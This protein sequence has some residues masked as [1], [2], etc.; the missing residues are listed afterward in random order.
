ML[1]GLLVPLLG[2]AQTPEIPS[3]LNS[4]DNA[5]QEYDWLKPAEDQQRQAASGTSFNVTSGQ[6]VQDPFKVLSSGTL[7]Q[8]K[9]DAVYTQR[10]ENA[11]SLSYETTSV[12]LN[13]ASNPT[14]PLEGG[15]P[16]DLSRGQKLGLQFQ[17]AEVLTLGC[18]LH[19]ATTDA[20][21]PGD[22]LI[23]SGFGLS[24]QGKLPFNAQLSLDLNSDRTST[25]T[26]SATET[27]DT[28]CNAEL[29]Q[30]LGKLPLTAVLK[31]H[32]EETFSQGTPA[33][34]LPSFEQS[35][36][37]KPL[38]TTTLQTGLRQQ[39]F[40]V[41]PGDQNTFNEALFADWSQAL[42]GEITWHSYAELLNSRTTDDA[43]PVVPIAS[44]AN[45]T[46]QASTPPGSSP[47]AMPTLEDS[48]LTFSTGPSFKLQKDI[49]ASI[50]Y[51]DR[52]DQNPVPGSVG[53]EQ[54]VSISVKGSF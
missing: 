36:V 49:S 43:A 30:P 23:T 35:L 14:L 44:G 6:D 41:F 50:E 27:S 46:P 26:N 33:S 39:Q 2:R 18:N 9:T 24:A 25:D 15:S 42:P 4:A 29:R 28:S 53:Q 40:Q 51:S 3:T 48:S 22:S 31:S 52:W 37:W 45:G 34:S 13:E 10:L 17:P 47:L 20:A 8:E 12:M 32:F 1:L 21:L 11:F 38:P 7:W 16:D 19:E 5:W 54:R